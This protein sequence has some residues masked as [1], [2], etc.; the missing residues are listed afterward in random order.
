MKSFT[1]AKRAGWLWHVSDLFVLLFGTLCFQRSR[2]SEVPRRWTSWTVQVVKKKSSCHLV[3]VWAEL[4]KYWWSNC[5]LRLQPNWSARF[6][7]V[8]FRWFKHFILYFWYVTSWFPFPR[9]YCWHVTFA[10][11]NFDILFY[12][13]FSWWYFFKKRKRKYLK[14]A[15]PDRYF[16]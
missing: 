12:F 9:N 4:V 5:S 7:H 13:I 1:W 3:Q 15:L 10:I 11:L 8:T 6:W 2:D 14:R 16:F